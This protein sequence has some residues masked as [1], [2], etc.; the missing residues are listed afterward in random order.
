MFSPVR[1]GLQESGRVRMHC[2]VG[3]CFTLDWPMLFSSAFS[4]FR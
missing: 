1:A 4:E 3:F 2:K